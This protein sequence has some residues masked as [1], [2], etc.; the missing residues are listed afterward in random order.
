MSSTVITLLRVVGI[1]V[2]AA[3]AEILAG[4]Q[5]KGAKLLAELQVVIKD[6]VDE[7]DTLL[8]LKKFPLN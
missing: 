3:E 5:E 7:R 6:T 1:V 4:H 2:R 8:G